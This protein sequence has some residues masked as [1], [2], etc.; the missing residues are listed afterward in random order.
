MSTV[1]ASLGMS[2]DGY[3][4]G[5]NAGPH[6]SLGDGGGRI[7]ECVLVAGGADTWA[8]FLNAGLID[9]LELHLAPVLLGAGIRPFDRVEAGKVSLEPERVGESPAVTHVRS[10]HVVTACGGFA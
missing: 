10:R 6:N 4:A 2:F 7:H 5:P 8:Q 3:I 1:P 9:Q